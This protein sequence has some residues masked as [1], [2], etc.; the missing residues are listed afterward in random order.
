MLYCTPAVESESN[1]HLMKLIDEQYTKTPFFGWP[2]MTA[3]LRRLGF[4]VNH[5]RVRRLMLKMGLQAIYTKPKTTKPSRE[6]RIYPYLLREVKICRPDQVW[7]ADITYVRMRQG[8]MYLVAIMDWFSRYAVAWE[9][10]N[11]LDGHFCLECL[12]KAMKSGQPEIFNTDQGAQF[13]ANAFTS[14]LEEAGVRIS[15]D[16]RGRA[17]DNIFIERLWR[18]V[19]YEEIYLNDYTSGHDLRSGLG[20]Y[21]SFYNRERPHQS[22]GYKTPVEFAAEARL[23][24]ALSGDSGVAK[25]K[26]GPN[27]PCPSVIHPPRRSGCS[28]AVALSS[29]WARSSY[30]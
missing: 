7:S 15:M 10:S 4:P 25:D 19:K 8:F 9:V 6:H 17:H 23:G 13:T 2:R 30:H 20:R 24:L 16:G 21:F 27:Q 29:G 12:S 5:K 26:A 14:S 18:S 28:P 11:T 1:L 3:H 22:L